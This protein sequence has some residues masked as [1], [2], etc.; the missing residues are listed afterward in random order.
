MSEP[1]IP[2]TERLPPHME[3]VVT[4]VE[5]A[6]VPIVRGAYWDD[7]RDAGLAC[8]DFTAEQL[9][10]WWHDRNSVGTEKL[11]GCFEPTHWM[12]LP[13]PPPPLVSGVGKTNELGK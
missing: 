13:P 2:V 1:W 9:R 7:G 10:G 11:E 6:T 3:L 12:P 4:Y 5:V 8:P